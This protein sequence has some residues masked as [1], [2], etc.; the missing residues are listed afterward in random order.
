MSSL[1][2]RTALVT[3]STSG[4]GA[5]IAEAFAAQGAFVVV[6]GRRK[7]LG[8]AVVERIVGR[9]GQAAFVAADLA[10]EPRQLAVDAIAAAG[11][12]IDVLVNNAAL[13]MPMMSTAET[14][15][16]LMDAAY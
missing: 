2:G 3:G 14:S 7:E 11:G 8:T 1:R 4:I 6:T 10:S 5:E 9:G 12:R 15:E 13:L 16:E